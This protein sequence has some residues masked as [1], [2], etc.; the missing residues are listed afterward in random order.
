[1][2]DSAEL[3]GA[4]ATPTLAADELS[5]CMGCPII[6]WACD[7]HGP[8]TEET[9]WT[10]EPPEDDPPT[11]ADGCQRRAGGDPLDVCMGN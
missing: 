11:S 5:E 2:L 8:I 7:D 4:D 1:M 6:T 9:L 10:I 3:S